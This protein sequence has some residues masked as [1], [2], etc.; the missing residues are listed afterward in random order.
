M[1]TTAP[2]NPP[3]LPGKVF[4]CLGCGDN[5]SYT[6]RKPKWCEACRREKLS[7]IIK[8]YKRRRW[9]LAKKGDKEE[10]FG[11]RSKFLASIGG[12]SCEEIARALGLKTHQVVELERKAL[13]KIR[14]NPELRNLWDTL[15]LE[16]ADGASLEGQR[17]AVD[18]GEALLD[19][20]LGVADWWQLHDQLQ[21][22]GCADEAMELLDEIVSFQARMSAV[23]KDEYVA[24]ID[25]D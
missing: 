3:P 8:R 11:G 22:Q 23:L 7:V 19:Y 12:A 16:L 20:Q 14:D 25:S 5:F 10:H 17:L 24:R 18:R 21:E 4:R 13:L 2:E 1:K 6:R 9:Q 15:K